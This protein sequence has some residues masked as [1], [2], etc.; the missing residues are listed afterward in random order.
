MTS[1]KMPNANIA[2]IGFDDVSKGR[3][4]MQTWTPP[5]QPAGAVSRMF[6]AALRVTVAASLL[7][8]T[9]VHSA[10][11]RCKR[12]EAVCDVREAVFMITAFD[13]LASA[14]RIGE[15]T[16][17]TNRHAIAD[18]TSVAITTGDGRKVQGRVVPSG[19]QADLVLIQSD[20]LGS[21]KILPVGKADTN[22]RL[23]VVGIDLRRE[24]PRAYPAGKILLPVAGTPFA[25]LHHDAYSQRG[26][27]GGA[28]VNEA[29]ALVGIVAS[30]G[31]GRFEAMPVSMISRLRAKSG[32]G[33]EAANGKLGEASR[34]CMEAMGSVGNRPL[35]RTDA[36]TIATAC[37]ASNNRQHFDNA[38]QIL[39]GRRHLD[40]AIDLSKEA[41][42]RD[43]NAINSRITL[44]TSLHFAGLYADEVEHLKFLAD[45]V[46]DEPSV[47]R[48][49]VQA[50]KWAGA[51]DLAERGLE[52][53]RKHNPAQL[54]AAERFLKADL[55][56]PKPRPLRPA[57]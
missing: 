29:G 11:D 34:L 17:V 56:V 42:A 38:A 24:R 4:T 2:G 51:A 19:F 21:G 36:E 32:P 55:P 23:Y 31:E 50:G 43:P 5:N 37:L 7:A 3:S 15:N 39:G 14:V 13:P 46:P 44:V 53:I 28:L 10:S 20:D 16:L 18:A 9:P 8:S 25:R 57:P 35:P 48:F 33:F 54:E 6:I 40:L 27:S 41:V 49:A 30:G 26:N 22:G 47:A 12:P 45:H 1:R 52:L